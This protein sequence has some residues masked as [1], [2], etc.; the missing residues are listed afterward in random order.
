VNV[1]CENALSPAPPAQRRLYHR[2]SYHS[3]A[4]YAPLKLALTE[5]WGRASAA[6]HA[7]PAQDTIAP[8]LAGEGE[9]W[10]GYDNR[11]SAGD[12]LASAVAGVRALGAASCH[13]PAPITTPQLHWAVSCQGSGG[14]VALDGLDAR[15][16][17]TLSGSF[18]A[19][20]GREGAARQ[21][22]T[23]P[24]FKVSFVCTSRL[25]DRHRRCLD[26]QP[27][28]EG[29]APPPALS[30]NAPV[31]WM[32]ALLAVALRHEILY[33]K[34]RPVRN[35]LESVNWCCITLT[36]KTSASL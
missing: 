11:P 32:T 34:D 27:P 14:A 22:V 8:R 30:M 9:V 20:A 15:Y 21:E 19:V 23:I 24:P 16:L 33:C 36:S 18:A 31:G 28:G 26:P 1:H 6:L 29:T 3:L 5:E 35:H 13:P 7:R 2:N 12:L 10:L 25:F 17:A 4:S